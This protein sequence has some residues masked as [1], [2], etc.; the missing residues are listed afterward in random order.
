MSKSVQEVWSMG[1]NSKFTGRYALATLLVV[2]VAGL[3]LVGHFP[4][5]AN[6]QAQRIP[7]WL[8]DP[9]LLVVL[10]CGAAGFI[11]RRRFCG[12]AA[13]C[14]AVPVFITLQGLF[15]APR[16]RVPGLLPSNAKV[17]P[18]VK[19]AVAGTR[20][21]AYFIDTADGSL[22]IRPRSDIPPLVGKTGKLT[23]VLGVF[24]SCG[25]CK[26][27]RLAYLLKYTKAEQE[28]L[29]RLQRRSPGD[30]TTQIAAIQA[31]EGMLVRR[32]ANGSRWFPAS[33]PT[34]TQIMALPDCA[35]G[36]VHRCT[37]GGQAIFSPT[38]S[39]HALGNGQAGK[40]G[41]GPG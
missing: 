10:A 18:R 1:R 31:F 8:A 24:Y 4:A 22:T 3:L 37:P 32:P 34:G 12:K 41:G 21:T 33:S 23:V 36:L 14:V 40:V 28:R 26:D 27:K 35:S 2:Q 30:R 11:A 20:R 15:Q 9:L 5:G 25:S 39:G 38:G 19:E 13:L 16:A 6:P 17:E 7:W 29:Q